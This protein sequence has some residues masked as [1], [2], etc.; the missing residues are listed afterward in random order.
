MSPRVSLTRWTFVRHG[1]STANAGGWLS[2]HRDVPLTDRGVAQAE[3]A[4]AQLA[5][6]EFTDAWTSDLQRAHHTAQ[7]LLA[8]RTAPALQVSPHL[9]ERSLGVLEGRDKAQLRADGVMAKLITWDWAPDG[10]E[11]H[12]DL[13]RRAVPFLATVDHGGHLLVVAH[14]GLIRV[15]VGLLDDLPTDAI[16]RVAYDNGVPVH[17]EAVT[18]RWATLERALAVAG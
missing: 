15:L 8:D 16:G 4:R 17:R 13:A 2:G 1:E 9:R 10:G 7:L 12:L 3:S 5:H 18:G 14:G 6:L 11:S